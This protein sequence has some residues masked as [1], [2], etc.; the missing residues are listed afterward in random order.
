MELL[1]AEQVNFLSI[2]LICLKKIANVRKNELLMFD[3]YKRELDSTLEDC[4]SGTGLH[5]WSGTGFYNLL[6]LY[7][8]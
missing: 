5:G 1:N 7:I 3:V 6:I 4:W 8:L 2:Y